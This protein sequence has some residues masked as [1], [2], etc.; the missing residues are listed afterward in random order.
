ML[1]CNLACRLCLLLF[2]QSC[3][4]LN[5]PTEIDAVIPAVHPTCV[6]RLT[7]AALNKH[8]PIRTMHIVTVSASRCTPGSPDFAVMLQTM[9]TGA[10]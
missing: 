1:P 3:V 10:K 2:L 7:L 5:A 4:A 9:P 8:F 6:S